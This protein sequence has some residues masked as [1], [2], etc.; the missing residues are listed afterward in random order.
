MAKNLRELRRRMSPE[1]REKAQALAMK[2]EREMPLDELRAARQMTQEHLA[3]LLGIRQAAISKLEHRTDMYLST[4]QSIV[5]A[6]GGQLRIEAVFPEGAVE[7]NQFRRL[8]KSKVR[9]KAGAS[10][11]HHKDH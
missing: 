11:G 10:S 6:M 3:R 7:I 5:K 2:Y 4:L 1:A 8:R 9:A